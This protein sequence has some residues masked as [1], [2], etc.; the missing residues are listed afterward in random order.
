MHVI[1]STVIFPDFN[2][3]DI[4]SN[5]YDNINICRARLVSTG[6]YKMFLY[7][8]LLQRILHKI[9]NTL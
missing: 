3:V 4:R 6:K 1:L 8:K 9:L 2:H 7:L 5:N